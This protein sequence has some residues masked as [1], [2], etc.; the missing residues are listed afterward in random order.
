MV[1]T[2]RNPAMPTE[3]GKPLIVTSY[4]HAEEPEQPAE[5]EVK[6]CRS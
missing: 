5:G 6:C 4:A 2:C 3:S 1:E